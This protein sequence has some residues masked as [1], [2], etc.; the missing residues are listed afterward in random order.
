MRAHRRLSGE[1]LVAGAVAA[2]VAALLVWLGPYG[3][4]F[5]A[6]AYQL[7]LFRREGFTL[8]D[9]YWYAGRY[10]FVGYSVL[11][12]PL[13]AALGIRALAVAAAA[14]GAFAFGGILCKEWGD[15]VRWA[16]RAFAPLWAGFVLTGAFPFEL[17]LSLA[18]CA[19]W[20]LQRGRRWLFFVATLL[21]LAASPVA[22]VLLVVVLSGVAVV[23][24]RPLVPAIAVVAA[25]AIEVALLLLFASGGHY[26]FPVPAAGAALGFCVAGLALTWRAEQARLL[27]W[28]FVAYAVAVAAVWIEPATLGENIARLRY[29]AF[30]LILLVLALR[31]WRPLPVAVLVAAAA[32]A[33]NVA[34][35]AEGWNRG[36]NDVTKNAA[37]WNAPLAWLHSHLR[38]GYRV[39]AVDTTQHWPAYYLPESGIPIVRGWFRQDDF[40]TNA[41]LYR[42]FRSAEYVRWLHSLGVAYV[43]LSDAPPDYSSRREAQIVPTV[44]HRVFASPHIGIY[45]VPDPRP[46]TRAQVVAFGESSLTVRASGPGE[47]RIAVHWSP[48]WHASSGRLSR[49]RDGMIELRTTAAATVRLSFRF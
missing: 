13:A 11:Y 23:R 48:Y 25:V 36:E 40:P 21:T 45:T 33:W 24:G 7:A 20:A 22:L 17:G 2:A 10:A 38:L 28:V 43:V 4:D 49:S 9:N 30:P 32:L 37:V 34:P 44:L 47:Y 3:T 46:I 39:E 27:R 1:A 5:A 41:L 18:L 12:Y 42:R 35:L 26:P 6:H 19:L 14:L 8:W 15:D 31:R 16:S 29:L